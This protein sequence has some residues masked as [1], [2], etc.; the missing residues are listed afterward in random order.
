MPAAAVAALDVA[1]PKRR[2]KTD[3]ASKELTFG[4][5]DGVP[6]N[7]PVRELVEV[8]LGVIELVDVV[9]IVAV[10]DAVSEGEPVVVGVVPYD[11]D[12]VC[13]CDGDGVLDAVNVA[14]G[15]AVVD[16][17]IVDVALKVGVAVGNGVAA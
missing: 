11:S 2:S 3:D 12:A 10:G 5:T 17:V 9:D 13:D 8:W 1:S 4:V 15:D 7:E 6:V 14:D 16:A